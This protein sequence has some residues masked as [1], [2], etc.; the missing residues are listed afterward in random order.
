M[1]I[2]V[3]IDQPDKRSAAIAKPPAEES[4]DAPHFAVRLA[5]A[6][7][8]HCGP[9]PANTSRTRANSGTTS[10]AK[11]RASGKDEIMRILDVGRDT[12][13]RS[14]DLAATHRTIHP[15][16]QACP[17]ACAGRDVCGL[18]PYSGRRQKY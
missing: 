15:H 9:N 5:P 12:L 16:D 17:R 4:M 14:G 11:R 13:R 2:T 10:P 8:F 18:A 3:K 1:C 6:G 7:W